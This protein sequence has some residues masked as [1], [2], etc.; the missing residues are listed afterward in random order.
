MFPLFLNFSKKWCDFRKIFNINNQ[1]IDI[2]HETLKTF[3]LTHNYNLW[4]INLFLPYIG[5]KILEVGCGIGNLTFY[6]QH[7]GNLSCIDISEHYLLHMRIDYPQVRFYKYDISDEKVKCLKEERF[8]TIVCINVLEHVKDDKKA[9][10][11]TFEILQS[12]GRLLLFVPALRFLYGSLDKNLSHF[13]R[14]EQRELKELLEA[15]GFRIEKISYSNLI[16]ILGWFL[17][18]KILK[19]EKLSY[20]QIILFDKFVPFIE[21]LERYFKLPLGMSLL[22]VAKKP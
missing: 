17:N 15:I 16:G 7:L 12:D 22:V 18:G 2:A 21:R 9:L 6:L 1:M 3:S 20:W 13:R 19:K 14:Y 4:I 5:K 11:N 8:D 10:L